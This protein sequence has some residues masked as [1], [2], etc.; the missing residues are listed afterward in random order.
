MLSIYIVRTH[1]LL[2]CVVILAGCGKSDRT[3]KNATPEPSTI[4]VGAPSGKIA[5]EIKKDAKPSPVKKYEEAEKLRNIVLDQSNTITQRK[6]ALIKL[7]ASHKAREEFIVKAYSDP[8]LK[9]V[10]RNILSEAMNKKDLRAIPW[11]IALFKAFGGEERID[12]EVYLIQYGEAAIPPLVEIVKETDDTALFGRAVDGLAKIGDDSAV[13]PVCSRLED[14]NSWIVITAAHALGTIGN[15][16]AVP[17]LVKLLK[18]NS[19]TASAA[20]VALGQIGD[21]LAFDDLKEATKSQYDDLRGHAAVA[22]AQ[23][24]QER[25][26]EIIT[27]LLKDKH[28]GVRF[29]AQRALKLLKE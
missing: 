24:G 9:S 1:L 8:S 4:S 11:T 21:P 18:G 12:F 29:Q 19:E 23:I 5:S 27:P 2:L 26:E 13:E 7:L 22:L 10:I 3:E 17:N 15:R 16:A 28:P 20:A 14:S 6:E 25:T